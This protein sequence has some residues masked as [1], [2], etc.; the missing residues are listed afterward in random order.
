MKK[1]LFILIVFFICSASFAQQNWKEEYN[2]ARGVFQIQKYDAAMELFLPV[3]SPDPGNAY[4]S[5]AQYYYALSAYN[6]KRYNEARQ[7]LLQLLNRDLKWKQ[8]N[9]AEYLLTAVYFE[10]KQYRFA[11]TS[12]NAISGMDLSLKELKQNYFSH[13]ASVD[14]LVKLQREYPNDKELAEALFNR[15]SVYTADPKNKMLYEYL[16]QEFKFQI[17][18]VEYNFVKKNVY[19]IAVLLPFSLGVTSEDYKR[20]TYVT[21]IYQGILVGIDSLKKKGMNIVV[22][23]YDTDKDVPKLPAILNY[24]EL[25]T[26]DLIIGPLYPALIPYVTAFSEQNKIP[27]INPVSVNSKVVENT[28]LTMLFQPALE[29]IAGQVSSFAK[30]QLM[31]RK[32]VAKDDEIKPKTDVVIFYTSDP[33][34]SLLAC[35]Y[36]DSLL[37]K[38]FKVP[39]FVG[40]NKAN[41]ATDTRIF[42][43]SMSLLRTSHVFVSSS[44]PALASNV[45]SAVEISRQ[46]IPIITKSDWLE[47]NNQTY[48]QYERRKVYFI[49]PDFTEFFKPG[50]KSFK[51]A[52]MHKY[53]IYPNKYSVLGFEMITLIGTYMN[54]YGTGFFYNLRKA[55]AQKGHYLGGFD[56]SQKPYNSYVPVYYFNELKLTPANPIP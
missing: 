53:D 33:K 8:R 2:K 34:D 22:H 15:L 4:A 12:A 1:Y 44:D 20:G 46:A 38:G 27:V 16:A 36:R 41:I 50:Y 28:T 39:K 47:I 54:Q 43:D 13:I 48:E 10:L 40:I 42:L 21:D 11:I 51:N 9:E 5:Y 19:H 29:A 49:Y 26:M 32:N 45:I 56:F 25:K 3:T 30:A 24:P 23:P 52:Y 35:Y 31:Y 7:M 18:P 55:P 6:A 37:T 14:T 17:K